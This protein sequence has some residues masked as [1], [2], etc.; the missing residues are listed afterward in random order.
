MHLR[1]A[2]KLRDKRQRDWL[3]AGVLAVASLLQLSLGPG[4]VHA[5]ILGSLF[6][7][8]ICAT[9][10]FRQRYPTIAG[11]TAQAIVVLDFDT[12]HNLQ[13]G[14]WSIAWWCS[15]YGLAV[16]STRWRFVAGVAFAA[17]TDLLP[18]GRNTGQNPFNQAALGLAV[19]T[20]VIALLV[21]RIVGDRDSKA[22]LAERER[23]V[24]AREAVVEERARIARELHDAVAHNVSM[25][26]IQAGAER[27]VLPA[28][29]SESESQTR[30]VLQTI[31]Q[32]GRGALTEMR[33]LV[34]MLRTDSSDPLAPQPTLA[35]LPTLMTQVREAGLPVEYSVDG[36]P[37]NLPVGIE[38][39]AYR[40]V[41]EALTNA[42]KH[43]GQARAAVHVR[44]G[45]D[46][47]EL[48]I[49]DDGAG[50]PAEVPGGG[51]GLA[52]I[53]ERVSLYGGKFD[54]ST[55]RGGG[56]AVRVLLPTT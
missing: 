42:L 31:E 12:W 37:R 21:R 54:A 40:I 46:C 52:G 1:L 23:D 29:E 6:A 18:A 50:A 4:P 51:H 27:R 39:S 32:I 14:F 17:F 49:T 35:D 26:V 19:G 53:R 9:V 3:V 56:F 36:E 38:L 48:E 47:L 11:V 34:G 44:Y 10:A 13:L 30:E 24:A 20:V 45:P 41:Q 22:R 43:A 55:Q 16:W 7:T 33:R 2:D 28:S 25:M 15:L 8:A 5:Q